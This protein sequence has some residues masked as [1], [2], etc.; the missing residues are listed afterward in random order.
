MTEIAPP[1][2]FPDNT[3]MLE[4]AM[5][6]H[7]RG[8]R[9]QAV[10]GYRALL[11]IAP[12]HPDALHLLGVV[13]YEGREFA[14]ALPLIRRATELRPDAAEYHH[15]LG[16][17]YRAGKYFELACKAL[18]RAVKLAPAYLDA[19][20]TL[21]LTFLDMKRYR[22][23]E[24]VLRQGLAH[25]PDSADLRTSLGSLLL[26]QDS[27]D[28]AVHAFETVLAR[29]P[30]HANALNNLGVARNLLGD[31]K[32]ALAALEKAVTIAPEHA[33]A[34]CNYAHQ[35]LLEGRYA[36]GWKHHEWRL[37]RPDYRRDFAAPRWRGE[38]LDGRR[39]LLWSEQGLGDAIQFVRYAPMV[40]AHGGRVTVEAKPQLH[41]LFAGVDGVDAVADIGAGGDYDL[42]APFMSLPYI[43][44]TQAD[45]IPNAVPYLP[46]PEQRAIEAPPG[47]RKIGLN[48]AGNPNNSRDRHRSRPLAE[49]APL[50]AV[51]GVSF[52]SLQWGDGADQEPPPGMQLTDLRPGQKDFHDTAATMAALDL[53]VTV[54]TAAAHL[55]GAL[56][57]PTWLILDRVADWR[58]PVEGADTPWYPTMRLY[59]RDTG[60]P[61]LFGRIARDL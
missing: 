3:E 44:E 21:G 47:T 59:R 8:D 54:D 58:W 55:A 35:L 56:G 27:Y 49:F 57:R 13:H 9:A 18:A 28:D 42:H 26:Q 60:W 33:H 31:R 25:H 23:C 11:E 10:A 37:E 12:D 2:A 61:S 15:S 30:N 22:E 38:A 17:L 53:I 34:Q 39:I 24:T 50:A 48:W 46:V 20:N 6:A 29:H 7:R 1:P 4:K 40:A 5:A 43:F 14:K 51:P 36:E 45:T 41:R 52:F 32:G 19:Y 16:A